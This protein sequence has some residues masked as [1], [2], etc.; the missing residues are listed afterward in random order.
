MVDLAKTDRNLWRKIFDCE[1]L[2]YCFSCSTC[3]SG[4]PASN[5]NPPLLITA[6]AVLIASLSGLAGST[7][8]TMVSNG[9]IASRSISLLSTL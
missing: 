6:A 7:F 8:I 3:I 1:D 2:R 4:C 9:A 5:A